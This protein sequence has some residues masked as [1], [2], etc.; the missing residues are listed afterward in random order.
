MTG[1]SRYLLEA[2]LIPLSQWLACSFLDVQAGFRC[3]DSI[4]EMF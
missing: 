2:Q 1:C 4:I 3:H